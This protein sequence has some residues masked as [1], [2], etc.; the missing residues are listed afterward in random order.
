MMTSLELMK[1]TM[2]MM[3]GGCDVEE[4]EDGDDKNNWSVEDEEKKKL[5]VCAWKPGHVYT[6]ESPLLAAEWRRVDRVKLDYGPT[7]T[8]R[9][10]QILEMF[11]M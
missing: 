3:I 8:E 11:E 4:E 10:G 6:T 1:F 9:K 2:I 5:D 7:V